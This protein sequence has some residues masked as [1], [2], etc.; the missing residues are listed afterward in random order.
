MAAAKLED[1]DIKGALHLLCSDDQ[2]AIPDAVTFAEFSRLHPP[3]PADR[4]PAPSNDVPALRV[5][6]VDVRTAIQ[7]LPNGSAAGPD[8]LRPLH[9]KDLLLAAAN[10]SPLLMAISDLVNV[11]LDGKTPNFVRG[12]IFG[13]N[14]LAISKKNGGVRP[15][16]V[17]TNGEGC[18]PTWPATMPRIPVLPCR[19]RDSWALEFPVEQRQQSE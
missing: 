7:S 1:G 8:G 10:N 15:I 4:R 9:L 3:A 11:L 12:T 5:T 13:A 2:L 16:A 18:Q 6:P 19:R 17:A 14:L